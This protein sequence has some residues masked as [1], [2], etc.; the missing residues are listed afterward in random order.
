MRRIAAWLMIAL[1]LVAQPALAQNVRVYDPATGLPV[2]SATNPAPVTISATTGAALDT[3]ASGT[4]TAISQNV[5]LALNGKSGATIQITGTWVG[6][7]QFEGTVDGTNWAP[8]NGIY[9]GT[10]TPL[11]TITVN[12]LVRLTPSGLA[13]FRI[14]STA[15]TSGTATISLRASAGT[16]GTFL[17]QSLT[18]GTNTIGYVVSAPTTDTATG[19]TPVV[20]AAVASSVVA[21][22]SAGNLYG[23]NVT[24]GA[25]AGYVMLFNAVSAPADGA[26]APARC[27]PLAANTGIEL[28]WRSVPVVFSTGITV[29][30]STTGCFT[31]T[32]SATAF[33]SA[34]A[35]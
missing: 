6:T 19:I 35:K 13:Q 25:S 20:T 1:A 11:T 5:A 7:L 18:A 16:G 34:D 26:V 32:A 14:T 21:K 9:A 12:G 24:S 22:A 15:W 17:N 3:T 31:K 30:F 2:F 33:I 8:I 28:G 4:I 23:L 10:S 29:V 27:I